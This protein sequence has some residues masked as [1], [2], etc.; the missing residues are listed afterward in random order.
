MKVILQESVEKLGE[1]GELVNVKRGY[2]RNFLIP[3]NL[4]HIANEKNLKAL[5]HHKRVIESVQKKRQKLSA[6]IKTKLEN[7]SCTIS[8]KVGENDKL[9]GSVTAL[10]IEKALRAEGFDISRLQIH[11]EEP[12]KTLG[13][14]NIEIKLTKDVTATLKLW[15]VQ[16]DQNTSD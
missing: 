10:D 2:A 3:R 15:V 5:E 1:S 7:F 13:V 9:F 11:L 8:K 14:F 16:K 12:I 6:Q 4:A